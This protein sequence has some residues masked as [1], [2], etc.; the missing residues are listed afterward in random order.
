MTVFSDTSILTTI[1]VPNEIPELPGDRYGST[2]ANLL[3]RW[4]GRYKEELIRYNRGEPY[5]KMVFDPDKTPG[6]CFSRYL[7]M[8]RI[9]AREVQKMA[10]Y[11]RVPEGV[12]EPDGTALHGEEP[13]GNM[14]RGE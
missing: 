2:V 9:P 12:W 14:G 10:F 5:D 8:N 11:V 13:N 3:N 1:E 4:S 7:G 6:H